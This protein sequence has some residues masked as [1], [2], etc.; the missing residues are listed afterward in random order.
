MRTLFCVVATAVVAVE[1]VWSGPQK[2]RFQSRQISNFIDF[3]LF[4]FSSLFLS[5]FFFFSL[6]L[7][8]S[9]FFSLFS[10]CCCCHEVHDQYTPQEPSTISQQPRLIGSYSTNIGN[11]T[12]PHIHTRPPAHTH[13]H[14][15]KHNINIATIPPLYLYFFVGCRIGRKDRDKSNAI[16]VTLA[17]SFARQLSL[18]SPFF[19][20]CSS[21]SFS[22]SFSS[23]FKGFFDRFSSYIYIY[24]YFIGK[25]S[26]VEN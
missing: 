22:P 21:S 25:W 1:P 12:H 11:I 14:V 20:P 13:P 6:S 18:L 3:P 2:S 9:L 19:S 15:Q 23:S 4:F 7:S 5:P 10:R 8:L 26:Q 17:F 16:R 24:M